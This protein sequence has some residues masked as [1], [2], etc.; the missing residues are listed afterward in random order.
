MGNCG[1]HGGLPRS[2]VGRSYRDYMARIFDRSFLIDLREHSGTGSVLEQ[3]I[4]HDDKARELSDLEDNEWTQLVCI[5]TT[6][7]SDF[8]VNLAPGQQ[9]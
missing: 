8:A 9:Q 2:P 1:T 7:V 4:A 5:E 3:S 6:N